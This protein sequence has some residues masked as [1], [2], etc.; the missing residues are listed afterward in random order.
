VWKRFLNEEIFTLASEECGLGMQGNYKE[1]YILYQVKMHVFL[2]ES[3][4][5][6]PVKSSST[7]G[8]VL[9]SSFALFAGPRITICILITENAMKFAS[10]PR[11]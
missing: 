8:F 3:N 11:W 6:C 9:V 4:H 5:S 10:L 7:L 1:F 2:V